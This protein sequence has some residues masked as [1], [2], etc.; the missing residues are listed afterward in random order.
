MFGLCSLS[1]YGN[2][3]HHAYYSFLGNKPHVGCSESGDNPTFQLCNVD[4][5]VEPAFLRIMA[6]N[7]SLRPLYR[8][9]L[10]IDDFSTYLYILNCAFLH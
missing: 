9:C 5:Q 1:I 7:F 8:R 3:L 4:F 6:V 2:W 10:S